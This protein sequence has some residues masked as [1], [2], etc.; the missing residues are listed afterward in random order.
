MLC[1]THKEKLY[2][3]GKLTIKLKI[4]VRM[5][6]PVFFITW[7]IS[8]FMDHIKTNKVLKL[9]EYILLRLFKIS[10]NSLVVSRRI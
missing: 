10:L 7:E 2:I 3:L 1:N 5:L 9:I 4:N 6:H 8:D